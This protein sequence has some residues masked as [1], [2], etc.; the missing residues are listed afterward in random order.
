MCIFSSIVIRPPSSHDAKKLS[1]LVS[2]PA[3]VTRPMP[4]FFVASGDPTPAYELSTTT[5]LTVSRICDAK[6]N[7]LSRF[8][9]VKIR[10]RV[11]RVQL[12]ASVKPQN[13]RYNP[14]S[15]STHCVERIPHFTSSQSPCG[16]QRATNQRTTSSARRAVLHEMSSK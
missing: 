7:A 9:P 3:T 12:C 16:S 11:D 8:S 10:L 1:S 4:T 5:T 6:L 13:P 2:A 15:G 14:K